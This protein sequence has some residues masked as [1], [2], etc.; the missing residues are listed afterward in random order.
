MYRG[1]VTMEGT[2][3]WMDDGRIR[4]WNSQLMMGYEGH[5]AWCLERRDTLRWRQW[6]YGRD[7]V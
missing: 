2:A 4:E 1:M 5:V 6:S 7:K 3:S